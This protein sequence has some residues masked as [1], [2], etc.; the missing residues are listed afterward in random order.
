MVVRASKYRHVFGKAQAK[1]SWYEGI[2]G[3]GINAPDSNLVA[4]NAKYFA[5]AWK[6]GGG[7]DAFRVCARYE[8]E[9]EDATHSAAGAS[10]R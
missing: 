3:A 4:C 5:I 9:N 6:G 2:Q 10:V 8:R 7:E 1:E